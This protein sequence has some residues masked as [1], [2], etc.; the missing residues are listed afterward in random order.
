MTT[1]AEKLNSK[2]NGQTLVEK[3]KAKKGIIDESVSL[4]IEKFARIERMEKTIEQLKGAIESNNAMSTNALDSIGEIYGMIETMTKVMHEN[5][6]LLVNIASYLHKKQ[7]ESDIV[8]PVINKKAAVSNAISETVNA[9]NN[10]IDYIKLYNAFLT[11]FGQKFMGSKKADHLN[12]FK[13]LIDAIDFASA[14]TIDTSVRSHWSTL[15][16][17]E[18]TF[19]WAAKSMKK[20]IAALIAIANINATPTKGNGVVKDANYWLNHYG[21]DRPVLQEFIDF[22]KSSAIGQDEEA[23]IKEHIAEVATKHH[24]HETVG[25]IDWLKRFNENK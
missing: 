24:T 18:N 14:D 4:S 13:S 17:N 19:L 10:G 23:L 3:M 12:A 25:F 11:T 20:A 1:L 22:A 5:N 15:R 2:L 16:E 9:A 8:P 6:A 7:K 21:I